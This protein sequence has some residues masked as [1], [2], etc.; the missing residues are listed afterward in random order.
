MGVSNN[1]SSASG[2]LSWLIDVLWS[3]DDARVAR[4]KPDPSAE[5]YLVVPSSTRPRFLVPV[6]QHAAAQA[7]LLLYNALRSP[8]TRMARRALALAL[9]SGASGLLLRDFVEIRG[10][11]RSGLSAA[12]AEI[13]GRDDLVMGIG[14]PPRGPNRKPVLQVFTSSGS[15]VGY[16]KIGWN[17]V[18]SERVARESVAL[19]RWRE[20]DGRIAR[21]PTLIHE[22]TWRDLRLIATAPL[23]PDARAHRGTRPPLGAL[24]DV[25]ALGDRSDHPVADN[26]FVARLRTR[27]EALTAAGEDRGGEVTELL[28]ALP[29]GEE[30]LSLGPC[31]GDW[32][33][34]NL[35][36]SGDRI[37]IFDWEHW[38]ERGPIGLDVLHWHFQ[39]PFVLGKK[40]VRTSFA[41][42]IASSRTDTVALGVTPD[43]LRWV[44]VLYLAEI[45]LRG[46]EGVAGGA[47]PNPRFHEPV[48]DLVRDVVDG[49]FDL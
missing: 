33:P 46:L 14:V 19:E 21:A 11:E 13:F 8:R 26:E 22:G 38:A 28:D 43:A 40:D 39:I 29:T 42:A 18:T 12:L 6:R 32:V 10:K 27:A 47:P 16:V 17:E 7:S 36:R 24:Q 41:H 45:V 5:A 34:W 48:R 30:R 2:D 9:K 35:A 37:Y 49:R 31:H 3:S 15:A 20:H 25:I 4:G 1:D 23:P 44:A